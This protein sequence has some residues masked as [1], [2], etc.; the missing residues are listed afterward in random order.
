[1]TDG[2]G[3]IGR[4]GVIESEKGRREVRVLVEGEYVRVRRYGGR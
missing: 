1:M 3:G 4:G 2:C